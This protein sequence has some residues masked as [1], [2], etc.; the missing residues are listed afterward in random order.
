MGKK[1]VAKKSGAGF[2]SGLKSRVLSKTS[3]KKIEKGIIHVYST[4]NN[5]RVSLTDENGNMVAGSSSGALGFKGAKKGTPY[6]AAKVGEVIA[7]Q[8]EIVGVK[9]VYVFVKGIGAGRVSALRAVTGRGVKINSI[10]D[11]TPIPF[12]GPR[13]RKARRV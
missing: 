4:Y 6:A 2:N 3:K 1:R 10:K 8:A 13:P 5:T 11:V 9:E 7:E 12:N